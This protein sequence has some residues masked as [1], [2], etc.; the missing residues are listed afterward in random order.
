[1]GFCGVCSRVLDPTNLKETY[2]H[3]TSLLASIISSVIGTRQFCFVVSDL[4]DYRILSV[5][6][7][8]QHLFGFLGS[9]HRVCLRN[10]K[11]IAV[12][13]STHGLIVF[14]HVPTTL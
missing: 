12:S 1:M 2:L 5:P 3:N 7:P 8:N 14:L 11:Y 4:H 13:G 9:Y 10:N 6:D